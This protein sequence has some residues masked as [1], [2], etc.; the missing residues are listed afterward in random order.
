[1][2]AGAASSGGGGGF[3]RMWAS[4][5]LPVA[6]EGEGESSSAS[7]AE[8]GPD[9]GTLSPAADGTTP[10]APVSSSASVVLLQAGDPSSFFHWNRVYC[11]H[12][13][14]PLEALQLWR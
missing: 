6:C 12:M 5:E 7:D 4:A 10:T 3:K 14:L 2:S 9:S 8:S 1:M 11:E 13:K